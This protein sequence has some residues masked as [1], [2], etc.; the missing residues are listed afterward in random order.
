MI[1]EWIDARDMTVLE[2]RFDLDDYIYHIRDILRALGPRPHVVAVCQPDPVVLATAALMS[3]D[4]EESRPGTMTF[5][6][7][8]VDA[9]LSP[10]VTNKLAKERPF[11]WFES[12]MIYTVPPPYPGA[13]RRVYPGFVQLASF[14]SMNL[15]KHQTAHTHYLQHRM[16]D[17]GDFADKHL[18]LYDE[19]LSVLDLT[20]KFY[21]QTVD[22]VFQRHLLPKDELAHRGRKAR[23]ERI[24]DVGRMT[25]E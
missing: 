25:V 13:G 22:V 9:R 3:D 16:D 17:D 6:G 20:E 1:T 15:E 5:I 11:S 19:Y 18:E 12:N 4:R 7:S 8:P 10:T 14:M 21:L 23:P 24:M 2:R